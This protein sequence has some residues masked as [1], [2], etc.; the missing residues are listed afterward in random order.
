MPTLTWL[1]ENIHLLL[2]SFG[3]PSILNQHFPTQKWCIL[4]MLSKFHPKLCLYR[5]RQ[6][7]FIMNDKKPT[8]WLLILNNKIEWLHITGLIFNLILLACVHPKV[9]V[10][11]SRNCWLPWCFIF[12][13][14][15]TSETDK[16]VTCTNCIASAIIYSWPLDHHVWQNHYK[17]HVPA[18]SEPSISESS[19]ENGI[20]WDSCK[21]HSNRFFLSGIEWLKTTRSIHVF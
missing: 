4:I 10:Q 7:L 8:F 14:C 15:L 20:Y 11:Q 5:D 12:F 3:P 19:S 18:F 1:N 6:V 17:V 13:I 21:N 16:N 2:L 9:S